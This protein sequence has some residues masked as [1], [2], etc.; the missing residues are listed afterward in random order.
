MLHSYANSCVLVVS[1]EFFRINKLR[2][3]VS[4]T[5][6]YLELAREHKVTCFNHHGDYWY[7]LGDYES[8]IRAEKELIGTI[9]HLI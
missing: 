5:D 7:N 8:F 4:L 3:I 1:Q 9:E 6:M 2:G